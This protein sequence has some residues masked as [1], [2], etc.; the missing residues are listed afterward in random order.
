MTREDI[1]ALMEELARKNGGQVTDEAQELRTVPFRSI[2]FSELAL[3][4]EESLGREIVFDAQRLR[5][6]ETVGDVLGFFDE[7]RAQPA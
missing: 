6:I 4:V 7:I 1:R 3:H 2:D 5:E